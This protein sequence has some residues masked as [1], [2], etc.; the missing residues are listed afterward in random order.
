MGRCGS[1]P[2]VPCCVSTWDNE[3]DRARC[4]QMTKDSSNTISL[5]VCPPLLCS[6]DVLRRCQKVVQRP[7][8]SPNK[9]CKTPGYWH[10]VILISRAWR[11]T[12]ITNRVV[13]NDLAPVHRCSCTSVDAAVG[14][15]TQSFK[16]KKMENSANVLPFHWLL[17]SAVPSSSDPKSQITISS[18]PIS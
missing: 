7:L 2:P 17:G 11:G 18:L 13:A 9:D 15:G 8:V 16:V 10:L 5:S 4:L 12:S 3:W 14:C 6:P 1:S